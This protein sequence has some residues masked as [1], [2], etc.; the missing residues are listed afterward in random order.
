[1]TS[2][3][4]WSSLFPSIFNLARLIQQA[5]A[6]L[7]QRQYQT[8]QPDPDPIAFKLANY[9]NGLFIIFIDNI[10]I[11]VFPKHLELP[12]IASQYGS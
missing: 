1:M 2:A 4:V 5:Y 8:R 12:D 3:N 6:A 10:N 7:K 9:L 11:F